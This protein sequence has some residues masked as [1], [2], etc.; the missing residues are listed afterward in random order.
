MPWWAVWVAN[1]SHP[2]LSFPPLSPSLYHFYFPIYC[3][4]YFPNIL[5][6][7]PGTNISVPGPTSHHS[8]LLED[9]WYSALQWFLVQCWEKENGLF[10]NVSFS[11]RVLERLSLVSRD[12]D[13]SVLRLKRLE[14][15]RLPR[16]TIRLAR[17]ARSF[18][19]TLIFLIET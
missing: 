8:G 3:H 9:I 7:L 4:L 16:R 19:Q 14:T 17:A 12:V 10:S 11:R 6:T 13:V 5:L 1:L 15:Y 18:S 2:R